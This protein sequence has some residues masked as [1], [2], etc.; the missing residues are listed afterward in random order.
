MS[1]AEILSNVLCE[2]YEWKYHQQIAYVCRNLTK[3][4]KEIEANPFI[5]A[6]YQTGELIMQVDEIRNRVGLE[7]ESEYDDEETQSFTISDA[8]TGANKIL[9][10]D[11]NGSNTRA[12]WYNKGMKKVG[13]LN[14][15]LFM[16]LFHQCLAKQDCTLLTDSY[17]KSTLRFFEGGFN[18]VKFH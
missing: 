6:M 5:Y 18:A 11:V 17:Y 13:P 14:S 7:I 1:K 15:H 10:F 8:V 2:K 12:Y 3:N 9:R 16:T 4:I